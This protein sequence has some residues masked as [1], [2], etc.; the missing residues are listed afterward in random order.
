ME[1][2]SNLNKTTLLLLVWK[3]LILSLDV[4]QYSLWW[5]MVS[6]FFLSFSWI[7]DLLEYQVMFYFHSYS[8]SYGRTLCTKTFIQHFSMCRLSIQYNYFHI[9]AHVYTAHSFPFAKL[10]KQHLTLTLIFWLIEPTLLIFLKR[11]SAFYL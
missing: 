3:Q 5:F 10:A 2:F 7:V 6:V 4:N 8:I 11:N 9:F 1:D